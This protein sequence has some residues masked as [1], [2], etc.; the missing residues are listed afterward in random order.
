MAGAG[1]TAGDV[2]RRRSRRAEATCSME[3]SE[4][5]WNDRIARL[6]RMT[7]ASAVPVFFHGANSPAF[8][9]AGLIHPRLR[10]AL[11]PH[12]LLNKKG[13]TIRV[14]MGGP[15]KTDS[16]SQFA[17]DRE[18]MDYL[19]QRTVLLQSRP[20]N[21][22]PAPCSRRT[23]N[24]SDQGSRPAPDTTLRAK[25]AGAVDPF[26]LREEAASPGRRG[27]A[28]SKAATIAY[29][30]PKPRGFPTPCAKLAG[31]ARSLFARPAKAPADPSIWTA[32]TAITC[33]CG[34][35]IGRR[36]RSPAPTD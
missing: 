28:C 16:L 6:I 8:H 7:G 12:E 36:R 27:R 35:R 4:P 5:P 3:I 30:S 19:R 13:H 32:L 18:A 23:F 20:R 17:T 26:A 25:I 15:V 34:S 9:L 33:I 31:C 10:T 24:W 22:G 14:A 29:A 21:S 2:S 1:R 11:L